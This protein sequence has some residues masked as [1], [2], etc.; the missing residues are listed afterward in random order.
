M[1]RAKAGGAFWAG[2]RLLSRIVGDEE[3][4][5]RFQ[6]H[7]A[8][9]Y[10]PWFRAAKPMTIS[11][12]TIAIPA[13][14][15]RLRRQRRECLWSRIEQGCNELP[16]ARR[17]RELQGD[18]AAVW[19]N[20]DVESQEAAALSLGLDCAGNDEQHLFAAREA[21]TMSFRQ[22]LVFVGTPHKL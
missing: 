3:E 22:V 10:G 2:V 4:A 14:M 15:R 18:R 13:P 5:R 20:G 16:G 17:T 11:A 19:F 6:H 1:R 7:C 21:Q 9:N 8:S 12:P